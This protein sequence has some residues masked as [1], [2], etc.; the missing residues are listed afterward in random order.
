MPQQ[1][2]VQLLSRGGGSRKTIYVTA[3]SPE[4]AKAAAEVIANEEARAS[5]YSYE[6]HATSVQ[7]CR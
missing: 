6:Y 4:R 2:E 5:G 3:S 7:G 1:Y